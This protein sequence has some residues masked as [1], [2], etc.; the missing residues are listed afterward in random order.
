VPGCQG[1]RLK[2][3]ILAV[4]ARA[5][6]AGDRSI[7]EVCA[8]S[9]RDWPDFLGGSGLGQREKLIAGACSRRIQAR[10]RFLLDVGLDYLS[11]D[12]AAA[13]S[14]GGERSGSGWPPRSLRAGRGALRA[15][16]PSI[17]SPAWD[18]HRLIETLTRLRISGNTLIVSSTTRR[19]SLRGWVVESSGAASTAA[20]S[21]TVDSFKTV[22]R[23]KRS[24][25]T[26]ASCPGEEIPVPLLRGPLD[27]KRLLTVVGAREHNLRGI[28]VSFPIRLPGVGDRVSAPESPLWSTTFCHLLATSSTELVSARPA[29]QGARP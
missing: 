9:V 6:R 28:D 12:R 17:G 7:A 19:P 13:R 11:A 23:N 8:L 20:R 4:H 16:E 29:H 26:V 10:L 21:S 25:W 18:N 3:E 1:T 5:L 24:L 27:R 22:L 14:P 15:G 2:P